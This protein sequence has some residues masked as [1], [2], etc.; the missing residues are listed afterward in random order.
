MPDTPLDR[1]VRLFGSQQKLA[2]ILGYGE[3]TVSQWRARHRGKIPPK[4]WEK[5]IKAAHVR[6]KK[7]RFE[8]LV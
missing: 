6:G 2:E 4:E 8:D 1:V 3:S 5:L 7:L